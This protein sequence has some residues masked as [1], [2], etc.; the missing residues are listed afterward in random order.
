MRGGD[1]TTGAALTQH[2]SFIDEV[3]EAVRRDQLFAIFRKYGWIG[4]LCILLIVGFAGWTEWTRARQEAAAQA[5]GDAVLAALQKPDDAQRA[6][7]LDAIPARTPEQKAMVAMLKA[8]VPGD[9]AALDPLATEAN[10]P[11]VWRDL[12]R[13]KQLLADT[14]MPA[15]QRRAG[16]EALTAPGAPFRL[17]AQEQIALLDVEA[18]K[19]GDA[20][21]L[22]NQIAADNDASAAL[23][24]RAG[25]LIVALGGTPG[26]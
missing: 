26:S 25:Q 22:L 15:D 23:R 3:T 1:F 16:F 13:F 7:A 6:T 20:V 11:P 2:D 19:T 4:A 9:A 21:K 5:F 17:L 10:L 14:S 12:A 18:G 24:N 8:A